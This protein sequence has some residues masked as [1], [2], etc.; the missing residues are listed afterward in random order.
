LQRDGLI[1]YRRGELIVLS[2]RG[3][4]AAA[5]GCYAADRRSYSRL[6]S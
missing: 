4:E 5:C 3:L 1:E 2:R 6:L